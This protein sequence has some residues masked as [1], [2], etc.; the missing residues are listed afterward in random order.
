MRTDPLRDVPLKDLWEV[1]RVAARLHSADQERAERERL[2][3]E[4]VEAALE[5]GLTEEHLGRAA[6]EVAWKRRRR[7]GQRRRWLHGLALAG[8]PAGMGLGLWANAAWA[9]P[10]R[11]ALVSHQDRSWARV[12]RAPSIPRSLELRAFPL[13]IVSAPYVVADVD[14]SVYYWYRR[15][16]AVRTGYAL[17]YVEG[18][19]R[20]VRTTEGDNL[21][22][23]ASP[24]GSADDWPQAFWT[25]GDRITG[26]QVGLPVT[27]GYTEPLEIQEPTQP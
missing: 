24:A 5:A 26:F 6:M 2:R 11:P 21:L 7:A 25:E 27:E 10:R 23:E 16:P 18:A 1:V 8:I 15:D 4:V 3:Q 17:A 9:P 13:P 12:M 20:W 19:P 14:G 22:I